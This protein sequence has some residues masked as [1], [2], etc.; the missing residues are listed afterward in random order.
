MCDTFDHNF[1]Y[2][3]IHVPLCMSYISLWRHYQ[4]F[5][6]YDS[7]LTL[8]ISK[9]ALNPFCD[10]TLHILLA[11]SQKGV[12]TVQQCSVENQKGATA[13]DFIQG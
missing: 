3:Y 7:A 9:M 5:V 4:N 8:K 12:N 2:M 10:E 6:L 11:E 1:R 13:I